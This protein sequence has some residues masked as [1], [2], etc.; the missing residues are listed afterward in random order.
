MAMERE[1]LMIG[2]WVKNC[3]G[4]NERVEQILDELIMLN[5]N[6]TY[7]LDEIEPIPITEEIL[8]KNGFKK[9]MGGTFELIIKTKSQY[10]V[11]N[12]NPISG[13]LCANST[14]FKAN[15]I[16]FVHELQH[17]FRYITDKIF[18]L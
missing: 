17:A 13:S 16:R 7:F 1:N 14:W 9:K 12:Y 8:S 3:Y 2:D 6:D 5:Y 11:I 10:I 15:E 4:K 18:E